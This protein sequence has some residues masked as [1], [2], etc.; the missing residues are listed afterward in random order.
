MSALTSVANCKQFLGIASN[1]TTDDGLLSR[2]VTAVSSSIESYLN[3]TIGQA[4]YTDTV[5]GNGRRALMLQNFPVTAVASVSVDG[6]VIPARSSPLTTGFSFDDKFVYLSG[7]SFCRG[8]QNVMVQYTA[9]YV[10]TPFDLEQA[11][12]DI[13]ALKYR[14]RDRIG[15]TS[16]V[17]EQGSTVFFRDVPPDVMRVLDQYKR[18]IAP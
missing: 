5:N 7:Y 18:V 2:L 14:G 8:Y 13:V 4:S 17:F 9:G 3:R 11:A 15:M 6:T 1:L 10:A 16:K 12:I